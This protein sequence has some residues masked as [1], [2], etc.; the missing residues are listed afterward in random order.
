M[1]R[2]WNRGKWVAW[3][4]FGKSVEF[5]LNRANQH[6]MESMAYRGR[7]NA[8]FGTHP[9]ELANTEFLPTSRFP[10]RRLYHIVSRE[11][12]LC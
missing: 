8:T 9:Y 5:R 2:V 10:A 12:K 4:G 3:G 1:L 11:N 6:S 7:K